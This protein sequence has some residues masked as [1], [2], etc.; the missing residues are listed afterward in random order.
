MPRL[1]TAIA[2]SFKFK[3]E[4]DELHEEFGDLGVDVLEPTKGWLYIP[5]RN[6]A[7]PSGFRPLPEERY[8][9]GPKEV[10]NRFL[11]AVRRSNFLY[12][13]NPYQY[14]GLSAA[15]EVGFAL[16]CSV[17]VFAREHVSLENME[18]RLDSWKFL[19]SA[20]QV[21]TPAETILRI[22]ELADG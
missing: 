3:K 15:M 21:A 16:G 17:P 10:E 7:L 9:P 2:G 11:T 12:L 20:I 5:G 18:Y 14:L 19:Q 6:I 1:K 8:M 22:R 4:I 13:Y